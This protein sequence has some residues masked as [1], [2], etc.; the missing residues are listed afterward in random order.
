M[1]KTL[2]TIIST[3]LILVAI[4]C[5]VVFELAHVRI[6]PSDNAYKDA[7]NTLVTGVI[8]HFAVCLAILWFVFFVTPLPYLRF[9]NTTWKNLL[10]CLP[11][12]MVALVNFPYSALIK[13]DATVEY[14]NLMGLYIL[15]IISIA[16]LEELVFRGI[17]LSY[18]MDLF[19]NNKLK[20]FWAVLISSAIF[21]LFHFTNLLNGD[22]IVIVLQQ[23][24]YTFLIGAMFAVI[25]LK[26][27][28]IWLAV[29][30]HALFDFGGLLTGTIASGDP[31][32]GVFWI[33]TIACGILCAGHIVV[34]LINLDRKHVS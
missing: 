30:A 20:H 9:K 26:C 21:S 25:T 12:L 4:S 13:G 23:V 8:Y 18:F 34:T 24:G 29:I 28:N 11:C 16:L 5:F 19:R 6:F 7:L 15:Y 32:D 10:W 3:I 27:K 33:L 31:H 22:G 1:N 2:K 14:G 17:L